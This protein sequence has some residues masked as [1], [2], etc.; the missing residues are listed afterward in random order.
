MF[1]KFDTNTIFS[2]VLSQ[3]NLEESQ[4]KNLDGLW[5]PLVPTV[6]ESA[7]VTKKATQFGG[8]LE[9]VETEANSQVTAALLTLFGVWL[10][11]F[12]WTAFQPLPNTKT[13]NE[14]E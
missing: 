10:C 6:L 13:N 4:N 2:I 9:T 3:E 1:R 12:S 14:S 11:S 7:V 8:W 5:W